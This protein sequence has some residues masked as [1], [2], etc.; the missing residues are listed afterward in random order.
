MTIGNLI[1]AGPG[2]HPRDGG[3]GG[4]AREGAF[5]EGGF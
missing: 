1:L 2:R 3:E 4:S 5:S